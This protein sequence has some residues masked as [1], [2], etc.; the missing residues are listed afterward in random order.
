MKNKNI[1]YGIIVLSILNILFFSK[2]IF[3]D[4]NYFQRD[5]MLQ[6]KPWKI[7]ITECLEKIKYSQN[8][9]DYLPLWNPYNFCGIPFIANVQAQIFYPF[10]LIFYILKEFVISFKLFVILHFILAGIFMFIYLENKKI[11]FLGCLLGSIIWNFNGYLFSRIEFLSVFSSIIWLPLNMYFIDKISSKFSIKHIIFLATSCGLQFLAGH[12]QIWF[13]ST[14]FCFLYS[15]FLSINKKN[16]NLLSGTIIGIIL[17]ILLTFVQFLPTLEFVFNSTRTSN[18]QSNLLP[19]GLS[20]NIASSYSIQPRDFLNFLYP[21]EYNVFKFKEIVDIPNYWLYTFYVGTVAIFFTIVFFIFSKKLKYKFFYFLTI[22]FCLLYALGSNSFL[23]PLL[24]NNIPVIRIFRYPA[25]IIYIAVFAISIVSS[26]GMDLITNFTKEK[27]LNKF[28]ILIP[29]ICFLELFVY[30]KNVMMLLPSKILYEKGKFIDF[31]TS[32]KDVYEYKIALTPKTQ[33]IATTTKG[34]TLY[35]AIV[36]YRDS[37][38]GNINLE[39]KIPNFRGQDIELKN[40]YMYMNSTYSQP[41]LDKALP[42]FS[43]ANVKYIISSDE[44]KTSYCKKIFETP[45]LKLYENRYAMPIIYPIEK[46][47]NI[48]QND[49]NIEYIQKILDNLKQIQI[50]KLTFNNNFIYIDLETKSNYILVIS[51]SFYP[52]WKCII[53]GH[54][55]KIKIYNTF[56]SCVEIKEGKNNIYLFYDPSSFKIGT[57]VSLVVLFSCF[58]YLFEK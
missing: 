1:L 35:E 45:Y 58:L 17:S 47:L 30:S 7:F 42:F 11:S 50:K 56:M 22:V 6:F 25:T 27:L 20:Y 28:L 10:S 18:T 14:S 29:F 43:L 2:I 13:Y 39:Y 38:L 48:N 19:I 44:Q 3:T 41:T 21:F 5:I 54:K 36:N 46:N 12:T 53:N 49:I 16:L 55:E 34:K 32:L 52:G 4:L 23:Y 37:F 9:L 8:Y 33:I 57:I 31:L 51:Q 15:L 26:K 40:F 24:Y